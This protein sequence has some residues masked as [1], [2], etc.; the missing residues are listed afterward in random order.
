[1]KIKLFS[2]FLLGIISFTS[3]V[4]SK[5]FKSLQEDNTNLQKMLDAQK[6]KLTDCES[7]KMDLEKSI[8]KLNSE[9]GNSKGELTKFQNQV[10]ELEKMN[11]QKE[12]EIQ[13]IKD[14]I[15][16][17]FSMVDG[18]DLSVKQMG[19][20]LYVSLP[21]R[22][23][24]KKGSGVLNKNGETILKSLS[25]VFTKNSG[26]K[27]VVEGHA[28]KTP[29]K[30]D[31]PF[32]DNLDLSTLRANNVVRYLLKQKVAPE[33]LTASGRS[34]FEPTGVVAE[35]RDKTAMDRRIEFII[36][37]DVSKLYELSKKK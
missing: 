37:P 14:E 11:K 3:C 29:V 30:S 20:K 5:K 4:S 7:S 35:G 22:I 15:H 13:R 17:A 2:L 27:V 9:I 36:S 31:A 18:A 23:L 19:D 26:M 33:Q 1:M 32:K 10:S 25:T 16:K 6:G 12:A 28:D 21:N 24:Y 34:S 8:A